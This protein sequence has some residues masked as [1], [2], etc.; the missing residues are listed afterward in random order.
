MEPFGLSDDD[1]KKI[2]QKHEELEKKEKERKESYKKGFSPSKG[3]N[4]DKSD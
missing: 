1:R 3:K 4:N 2:R